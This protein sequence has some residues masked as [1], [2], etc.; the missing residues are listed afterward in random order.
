M[1]AISYVNPYK[2]VAN[3]FC[4][5]F[6]II[7]APPLRLNWCNI[8]TLNT[9]IIIPWTH[10]YLTLNIN[11]KESHRPLR[12]PWQ[13]LLRWPKLIYRRSTQVRRWKE[14]TKKL[15]WRILKIT[16]RELQNKFSTN[17]MSVFLE[18][19]KIIP[20]REMLATHLLTH[21]FQHSLWLVKIHMGPTKFT[22]DPHDLVGPMWILTN[23][24]ECVR[25]CV[26]KGVL[27]AFLI[28]RMKVSRTLSW[29]VRRFWHR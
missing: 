1:L 17:R 4:P 24:R 25:K 14:E 28:P 8:L 13:A 12:R 27:L 23:Q 22:W 29:G 2:C 5:G 15:L 20:R 11:N 26:L 16:L 18:I 19:H 7:L 3:F 9:Q 21:T 10:C 6:I